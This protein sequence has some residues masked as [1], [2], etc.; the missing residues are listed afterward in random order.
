MP[1]A[2]SYAADPCSGDSSVHV[3]VAGD[4]NAQQT[5]SSEDVCN[6]YDVHGSPQY[7]VRNRPGAVPSD[8]D[9]SSDLLS[10]GWLLQNVD[11][12]GGA[13]LPLNK[14]R[15]VQ[16]VGPDGAPHGLDKNEVQNPGSVFQGT[17]LPAIWFEQGGSDTMNYIRPLTGPDD[18]NITDY[19]LNSVPGSALEVDVHT[20]GELLRPSI[21]ATPTQIDAGQKVSFSVSFADPQP[22]ERLQYQW[23]FGDGATS[24]RPNPTHKYT[25]ACSCGVHLTVTGADTST[26]NTGLTVQVGPEP[27]SPPTTGPTQGP[28]DPGG[29]QNS[30]PTSGPTSSAPTASG[31]TTLPTTGPPTVGPT[32]SQSVLPPTR[33]SRS[34][35]ADDS[36]GEAVAGRLLLAG[37]VYAVPQASPPP[38]QAAAARAP[39]HLGR[40]WWWAL[41]L[42][43]PLLIGLG[44]A[45][46]AVQV[47]RRVA[48]MGA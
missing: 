15:F 39:D 25:G 23:N 41:S 27:T 28:T 29:H 2:P 12:G 13:T 37:Q 9:T 43:F 44:V 19:Y 16:I 32:E 40:S 30:G 6:I 46:E 22:T 35:G 34:T 47:R 48:R 5:F 3:L 21:T 1:A 17:L 33:R 36:K 24:T 10:I 42:M 18:V 7:L 38:P 26:G 4:I 31:P 11:V 14:V 45:G 8:A 20:K